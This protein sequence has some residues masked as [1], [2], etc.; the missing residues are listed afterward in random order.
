MHFR[1]KILFP[2]LLISNSPWYAPAN[3]VGYGR[4]P[5]VAP[6]RT[7]LGKEH[8][9]LGLVALDCRDEPEQRKWKRQYHAHWCLCCY[10][11]IIDQKKIPFYHGWSDTGAGAGVGGCF[12]FFCRWV[13]GAGLPVNRLIYQSFSWGD[14]YHHKRSYQL[15]LF[16]FQ[17]QHPSGST[18]CWLV[19]YD[20]H[21][22][23]E[24]Y[25]LSDNSIEEFDQ[26]RKIRRREAVSGGKIPRPA[27]KQW[28]WQQLGFW[29]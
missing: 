6:S 22:G 11:F 4:V 27:K 13:W 2:C 5:I 19:S 8:P 24:N 29:E 25:L 7:N 21:N 20:E 12:F 23:E 14:H 15:F 10:H 18:K 28:W 16:R 3:M 26:S 9:V 17:R 1:L